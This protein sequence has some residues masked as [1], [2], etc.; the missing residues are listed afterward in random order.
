[1]FFI[2][3]EYEKQR[4]GFENPQEIKL[5]GNNYQIWVN[6]E[7]RYAS[8]SVNALAYSQCPNSRDLYLQYVEKIDRP[9]TWERYMGRVVDKLYKDIYLVCRHYCQNTESRNFDLFKEL[10]GEK[11]ILIFDALKHFI[12]EYEAIAP[13]PDEAKIYQFNDNLKKIIHFEALQISAAM[14]HRMAQLIGA[15]PD[16]TFSQLFPLDVDVQLHSQRL[17][18][19][20]PATPDFILSDRVV[21]DIKLGK[22]KNWF[23]FTMVAYALAFEDFLGKPMNLG[24]I[25][26]L[27]M[28]DSRPYPLHSGAKIAL[29]DDAIRERFITA[30]NWKLQIIVNKTDPGL[31]DKNQCD[32][33]CDYYKNC[34]GQE[35]E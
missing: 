29:L 13:A 14:E 4:A 23:D 31:P 5:R 24:A 28:I 35:N 16:Q 9:A 19:T 17:G 21:G 22:W 7:L 34:W 8:L 6:A 12:S 30:R 2:A 11:E 1:M 27:E 25:L 3:L 15:N 18:F 20:S 10:C 32:N 33:S 26:Q